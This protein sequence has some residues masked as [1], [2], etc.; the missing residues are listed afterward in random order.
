MTRGSSGSER[1]VATFARARQWA[2]RWRTPLLIASLALFATGAWLSVRHLGIEA[3]A[4]RPGPLVIQAAL[5]PL[6]VLYAGIGMYLLA[7]S[8]GVAMPLGRATGLSSWAT[9]AE[10]LP[11][12][13]GAMVRAGA[14]IAAGTALGQSSALVLAN[15]ILWISLAALGCGASLIAHAVPGAALIALVGGTGVAASLTWLQQ[16]A[17]LR[18]M[19]ETGVH[20]LIGLGLVAVRLHFAFL[21]LGVVVPLA[22][23][24]PF[25]LANIAGSAA[26]IAPAGLGISETLAAAAAGTVNVAPG[27][28][29][30]AVGLDRL[31]CMAVSALTA[32]ATTRQRLAAP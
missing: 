12:P 7:R 30:L 6:S 11:V 8:A 2:A 15:A 14:L 28:A 20:R 27:A 25:A 26:S 9:L 16:R 1:F 22:D 23:T 19:L 29:F 13:G 32:L 10:A 5:A 17:G 21:T 24:L 4:L 3:S 18:L 31:I